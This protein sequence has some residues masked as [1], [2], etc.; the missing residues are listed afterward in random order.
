MSGDRAR[1][2]SQFPVSA[3]ER[4]VRF[5]M[6]AL[7]GALLGGCSAMWNVEHVTWRTVAIYAAIW[8]TVCALMARSLGDEFWRRWLWWV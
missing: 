2:N 7:A 1:A 4:R 5:A 6:G 3:G 8:G